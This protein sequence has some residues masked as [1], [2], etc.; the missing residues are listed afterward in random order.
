MCHCWFVQMK[1]KDQYGGARAICSIRRKRIVTIKA[2][3]GG[4]TDRGNHSV[5]K[6]STGFRSVW[7]RSLRDN[8]FPGPVILVFPNTNVYNTS[9][10]TYI[11]KCTRATT[12]LFVHFV[13]YICRPFSVLFLYKCLEHDIENWNTNVHY[14]IIYLFIYYLFI[15]IRIRT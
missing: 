1:E 12:S 2:G 13:A 14:F 6:F 4:C 9:G 11:G 15:C 3:E 8:P 10:Q 5:S 7:S